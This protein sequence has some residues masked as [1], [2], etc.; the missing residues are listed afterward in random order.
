MQRVWLPRVSAGF[1][2]FQSCAPPPL[3]SGSAFCFIP[4]VS[5]RTRTQG[6]PESLCHPQSAR[7]ASPM[8]AVLRPSHPVSVASWGEL[9]LGKAGQG[10]R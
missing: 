3:T 10:G 5:T 4:L 1:F 8:R 2:L 9:L 6:N 7:V